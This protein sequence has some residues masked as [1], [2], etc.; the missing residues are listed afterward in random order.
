MAKKGKVALQA[1]SVPNASGVA[2]TSKGYP[3]PTFKATKPA[4]KVGNNAK[5]GVQMGSK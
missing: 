3:R 5:R 4:N 1:V 2:M